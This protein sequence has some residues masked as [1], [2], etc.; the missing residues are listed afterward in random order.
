MG[1]LP[2]PHFD[3]AGTDGS[4]VNWTQTDVFGEIWLLVAGLE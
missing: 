4:G 2:P 3:F 1:A